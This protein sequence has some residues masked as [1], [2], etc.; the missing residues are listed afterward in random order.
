M[1]KIMKLEDMLGAI[2]DSFKETRLIP[3]GEIAYKYLLPK[4]ENQFR[5]Y[6]LP[7]EVISKLRWNKKNFVDFSVYE[8]LLNAA[9]HG[10]D[11][12]G[13]V[14]L[15]LHSGQKG[16]VVEVEDEGEGMPEKI[17]DILKKDVYKREFL[18][19]KGKKGHGF[20][21]AR[22][23]LDKGILDGIGFNEKR[24]AIYLMALY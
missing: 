13:I 18:Y 9:E 2:G 23:Y 22:D 3:A 1:A 24:N 12:K 15:R 16:I 7:E 6:I 11:F 17:V 10:N 8:F 19:N 21:Y 4:Q 5:F 20:D 14:K